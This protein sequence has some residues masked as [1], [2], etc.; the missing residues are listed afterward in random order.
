MVFPPHAL[1]ILEERLKEHQAD[2]LL[3][4]D[5]NITEMALKILAISQAPTSRTLP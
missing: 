1:L 3:D 2:G 4:H 5:A